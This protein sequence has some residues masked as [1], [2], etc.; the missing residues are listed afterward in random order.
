MAQ[1]QRGGRAASKA[2]RAHVDP[3]AKRGRA[4]GM[5]CLEADAGAVSEPP[6]VVATHPQCLIR[7][8]RAEGDSVFI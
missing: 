2:K 4:R 5:Q 7:F 8:Y 6:V 3:K 1:Q